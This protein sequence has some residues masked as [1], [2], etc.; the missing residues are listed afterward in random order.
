M[1]SNL[2][3]VFGALGLLDQAFQIG[4]G[5]GDFGMA[6]VFHRTTIIRDPGHGAVSLSFQ[7]F[8]AL[9]EFANISHSNKHFQNYERSDDMS[10]QR[11]FFLSQALIIGAGIWLSGFQNVHWFLYLP[12]LFL[13]FAGISGI[14]P[15][16][17]ILR[18]I[19]LK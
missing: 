16:M 10:A 14:C 6:P 5:G 3:D 7:G 2:A 13:V 11:V 18:K 8:Q 19:G 15:G 1:D 9:I 4:N 17:I 12:V